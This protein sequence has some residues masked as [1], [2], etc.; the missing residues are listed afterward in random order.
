LSSLADRR[1]HR[2]DALACLG[3]MVMGSWLAHSP[4]IEYR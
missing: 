4:R 1:N 3:V 2:D